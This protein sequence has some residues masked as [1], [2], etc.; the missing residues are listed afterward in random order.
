M[1]VLGGDAV[2]CHHAF[3][4]R[5]RKLRQCALNFATPFL[6]NDQRK[7]IGFRKITVVMRLLFR[8][9]AIGLAFYGIVE[10]CLLSDLA[11]GFDDFSLPVNLIFQRLPNE[12]ERIN[13][14]HFRLG[15]EFLLPARTHTDIGIATQ[16]AFFHIAIAHPGVKD[17]LFQ[18][19]QIFVRFLG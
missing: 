1:R 15:A 12:A 6:V 14:L 5:F 11:T 4:T 3:A 10:P 13:V 7:Q 8:A 2:V 19:G 16:R 9:H 17:D 18:A